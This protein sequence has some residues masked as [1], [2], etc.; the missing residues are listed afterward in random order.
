MATAA[1]PLSAIQVLEHSHLAHCS[2]QPVPHLG[3]GVS[4]D[5]RSEWGRGRRSKGGEGLSCEIERG[6]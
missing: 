3:G 2:R 5:R 4:V 6:R 1:L